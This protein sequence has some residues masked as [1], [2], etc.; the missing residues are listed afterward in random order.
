QKA[1]SVAVTWGWGSCGLMVDLGNNA[2]ASP[3]QTR[4]RSRGFS[5]SVIYLTTSISDKAPSTLAKKVVV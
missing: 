4:P 2:G 3:L 5:L 1:P